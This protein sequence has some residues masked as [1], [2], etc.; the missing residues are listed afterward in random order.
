MH[1]FYYHQF[2]QKRQIYHNIVFIIYKHSFIFMR[3]FVYKY[4]ILV[5]I[6]ILTNNFLNEYYN[7]MKSQYFL[8]R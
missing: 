4:I 8:N 2:L 3:T 6:F 1:L 7:I 5:F